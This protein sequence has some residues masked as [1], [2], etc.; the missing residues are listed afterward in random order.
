MSRA[1]EARALAV[2]VTAG[3]Q[4]PPSAT[5]LHS[6]A[7]HHICLTLRGQG[8]GGT[9]QGDGS[10]RQS[11]AGAP[12]LPASSCASRLIRDPTLACRPAQLCNLPGLPSAG[13]GWPS[14][15]PTHPDPHPS[16]L[17]RVRM[18][19]RGGSS[20]ASGAGASQA[21]TGMTIRSVSGK[22]RQGQALWD[23]GGAQQR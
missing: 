16:T 2:Q 23:G 15:P 11:T 9:R 4:N 19:T 3:I 17:R 14:P 8:A 20:K 22:Q 1:G 10:R 18:L 7:F 12:P 5:T 6:S 21:G 13:P